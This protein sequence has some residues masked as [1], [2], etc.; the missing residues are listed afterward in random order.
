MLESGVTFYDPNEGVIAMFGALI[1]AIC[2]ILSVDRE[3]LW[4]PISGGKGAN[5]CKEFKLAYKPAN[6]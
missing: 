2:R 5:E 1:Q 4:I 6:L 3:N